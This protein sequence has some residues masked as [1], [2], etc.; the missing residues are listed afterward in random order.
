MICVYTLQ[1]LPELTAQTMFRD[2]AEQFGRRQGWP[3]HVDERGYEQDQYDDDHSFYIVKMDE[4]G[5]HLASMRLRPTHVPCM[6]NEHFLHALGGTPIE[7]PRIFEVTRFLSKPDSETSTQDGVLISL[8]LGELAA[9]YGWE[10]TLGVFDP[11]MLTV[12][13]R[14]QNSPEVLCEGTS[15]LAGLWKDPERKL[16]RMCQ[17]FGIPREAI[18]AQLQRLK[19]TLPAMVCP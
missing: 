19:D 10:A 18:Q 5:R 1:T 8:F 6:A 15:P 7:D 13:E 3:V 2:R 12:Y 17:A 9:Q 11:Y 16:P 14:Q 4:E